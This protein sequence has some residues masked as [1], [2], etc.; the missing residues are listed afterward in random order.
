MLPIVT[1]ICETWSSTQGGEK[2]LH[3]FE[4]KIL[5]KICGLVYNNDLE[6]F[7]KR[8]NENLRQLYNKPSLCHFFSY[9]E[10]GMGRKILQSRELTHEESYGK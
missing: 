7:E 5:R 9:K 1:Y 10:I 6:R 3:S 8:T 2:K 4:K